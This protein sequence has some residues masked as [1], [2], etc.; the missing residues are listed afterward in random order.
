MKISRSR[1]GDI[2]LV[3][4]LMVVG[5]IG[6]V[7][8]GLGD[9]FDRPVDAV[10]LALVVG[11]TLPLLTRR[12]W[13]LPT[14]A[15][16][17]VLTTTYLLLSYPYGPIFFPFL[18]AVYTV[19]RLLPPRRSALASAAVL[20]VLLT[21]LLTHAA[22]LPG[23]AGFVPATGWVVVPFAIGIAVR[24]NAES[25]ERD[26][27]EAVR[28]RVD[29][30]RLRVAQEVHDVVG[31]GLAAIKMQADLALHLLA[32]KPEQAEASLTAISR[33]SGEALDELRATLAVVRRAESEERAP[34]P[35]LRR[36]ED[37]RQRMSEA[38]VEVRI[39]TTGSERELSAAADLASYR[40]VQEALTNVL[41]HS[42]AKVATV[43]IGYETDA[44]VITVRNPGAAARTEHVGLGIPGMRER[45]TV[46]GG[47][48][49]AGPAPDGFFEVRAMIP[50]GVRS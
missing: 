28:Q 48:F 17:T 5:V 7:I 31:H 43:G 44:V 33:T 16:V 46:L 3:V 10:A 49:E 1:L 23:F 20:A 26:R 21:H 18:I 30:E 24:L 11:N 9:D 38:G 25:I 22:A 19:A 37:L 27:A 32:K 40:I 15:T 47:E 35:G 45:V 36:L 2:A 39:D 50:T 34:A 4:V 12:Q 42:E 6:T 41:R 14:L 13:P 29:D 8:T